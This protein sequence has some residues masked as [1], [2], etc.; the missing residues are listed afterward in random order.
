[1][2]K[3]QKLKYIKLP[4]LDPAEVRHSIASEDDERIYQLELVE[5]QLL[6][7]TKYCVRKAKILKGDPVAVAHL[8]RVGKTIQNLK[9]VHSLGTGTYQDLYAMKK[10]VKE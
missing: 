1:M 7:L 4:K 9:M 5:G 10:V 3:K 2:P 8:S 6:A